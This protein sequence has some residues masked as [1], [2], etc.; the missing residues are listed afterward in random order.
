MSLPATTL[1]LYL[2]K[3]PL[4][5]GR[6]ENMSVWLRIWVEAIRLPYFKLLA[7]AVEMGNLGLQL[8]MLSEI[9]EWKELR[10]GY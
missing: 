1:L 8:C 5:L 10:G 4:A 6:I 3:W 7:A 2:E 9:K